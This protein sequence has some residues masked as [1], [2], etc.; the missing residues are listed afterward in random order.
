MS[1]PD[2][3]LDDEAGP[4]VRPYAIVQGRTESP[5]DRFDLI[6]IIS[7][8][9]SLYVQHDLEPEHQK[10]LAR[11]GGAISVV[12]LAYEVRLPIGVV[13]VLLGDLLDRKLISIRRPGPM[14]GHRHD[15]HTLKEVLDGLRAL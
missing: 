9:P 1:P 10:V 6:T 12:D 14:T 8:I 5:T 11:C 3:W 2:R 4:I 15:R 13:R 7:A